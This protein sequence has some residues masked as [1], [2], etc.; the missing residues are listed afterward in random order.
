M[1]RLSGLCLGLVLLSGC[2]SDTPEERSDR[3]SAVVITPSASWRDSLV[4]TAPGGREVWFT[5]GRHGQGAEGQ[6]CVERSMQIR[7]GT[8][9]LIVPLLYTGAAPVLVDDTTMQAE[10]WLDCAPGRTYLVHLGTG[11]PTIVP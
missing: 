4:L 3:P 10:L 8:D 11:R 5:T 6:A 1:K 9:T 2:S 7:S